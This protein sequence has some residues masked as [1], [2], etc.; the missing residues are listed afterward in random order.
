VGLHAEIAGEGPALALV[1]EAVCD[2]RMWDPQWETFTRAYRV[3]RYDMRGFGRSPIEAGEF[4]NAS[5]LIE[6]LA[7][8]GLEDVALVGASMGSRVALEVAV[9]RPELV[10][11]LVLAEPGG[12]GHE[13]SDQV[14]AAWEEEEAAIEAGDLDAAVEVNLRTWVD[15]PR[16]SPDEVAPGVRDRVGAMQRQ[17][18]ELQVPVLESAREELLV[19]DLAER[20]GE[21]AVPTLVIAADEDVPDIAVIAERLGRE[22]P[23]ARVATIAGAAHVPNMER[24]EEFSELVLGFLQEVA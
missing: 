16:R 12:P 23:N 19:P 10:R 7:R 20:L 17:A 6:L 14:K 8:N 1:H 15:G 11:A 21:I 24:P 5:D 22:M 9:A 4:S 2:S 18:L 13:W 3:L